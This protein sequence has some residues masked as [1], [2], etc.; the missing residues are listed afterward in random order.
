MHNFPLLFLISGPA[1]SGK[2]TLCNTILE[3]LSPQVERVVTATTRPPRPGE[4]HKHHYHFLS[5]ADFLNKIKNNEFYEYAIVHD[6]YY[7]S[8]KTD[9]QSKLEQ[10][11][12]LLLNIDVQGVETFRKASQIDSVL[13]SRLVTIFIMPPTMDEL[14]SRLQ[15]RNQD[16]SEE[17]AKRL[18]IAKEE[19]KSWKNYNYCIPSR[20]KEEDFVALLSIYSA[21]KLRIRNRPLA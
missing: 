15:N 18:Q 21:E 20:S 17:I 2:T 3:H 12:D 11:I 13:K 1:G 6:Y 8:L 9:I 7:G 5:E 14:R 16:S 19:M 10:N 4:S